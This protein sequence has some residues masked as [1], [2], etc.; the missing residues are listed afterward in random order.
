VPLVD[1]LTTQ[2]IFISAPTT[3]RIY[4]A[5]IVG[6]FFVRGF[7][8]LTGNLITMAIPSF[9]ISKPVSVLVRRNP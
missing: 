4:R 3:S 9:G 2:P 1:I 8:M 7:L 6:A 5:E